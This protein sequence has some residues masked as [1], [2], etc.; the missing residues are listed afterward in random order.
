VQK[1]LLEIA[2]KEMGKELVAL[3]RI[4]KTELTKNT[5]AC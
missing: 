2:L 5:V 4:S 1:K 3:S